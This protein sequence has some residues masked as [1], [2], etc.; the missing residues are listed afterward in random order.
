MTTPKEHA[1]RLA[2]HAGELATEAV[3]TMAGAVAA[4]RTA[5][6][7]LRALLLTPRTLTVLG[8][9]LAGLAAGR[10][11]RARQT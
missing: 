10:R 5:A 7:K 4:P 11:R 2:H 8:V 9:L 3:G 6:G 1:T